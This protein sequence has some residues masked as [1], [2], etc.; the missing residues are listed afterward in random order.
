MG[1]GV[2]WVMECSGV[3]A[4]LSL[5]LLPDLCG[6]VMEWSAVESSG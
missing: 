5:A 4:E 3:G 1:N 2:Q 6:V